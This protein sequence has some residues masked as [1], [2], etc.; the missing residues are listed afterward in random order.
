MKKLISS[1]LCLT[2]VMVCVIALAACSGGNT[3]EG[4]VKKYASYL[5]NEKYD[6]IVDLMHFKKEPTKE[7]KEEYAILLRHKA[8]NEYEK[9]GGL[10]SI[11][12]TGADVAEGDSTAR[13]HTLVHY[14]D[15]SEEEESI[16]TVLV[17]G[18]WMLDS[19]K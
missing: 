14:R 8:S 11:E 2:F 1:H 9:H 17:D 19:G 12:I 6:K 4:V 3:P 10:E 5:Q 15:G 18:K 13:V 7:D 16:S